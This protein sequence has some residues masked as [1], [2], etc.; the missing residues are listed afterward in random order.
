MYT[1]CFTKKRKMFMRH[2]GEKLRD[3][4]VRP[5]KCERKTQTEKE[6]KRNLG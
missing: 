3:V 6:T 1:M 4:C 2:V 5:R